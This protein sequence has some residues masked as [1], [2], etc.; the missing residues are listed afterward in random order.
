MDEVIIGRLSASV[1]RTVGEI[2]AQP[3]DEPHKNG[4][5]RS[6]ASTKAHQNKSPTHR[7][8]E[9]AIDAPTAIDDL[10]STLTND[11]VGYISY[12]LNQ[13][14]DEEPPR[15][16]DV[17]VI[18]KLTR[19]VI[20]RTGNDIAK[21]ERAFDFKEKCIEAYVFAGEIEAWLKKNAHTKNKEVLG[22]VANLKAI[23]QTG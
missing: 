20:A 21:A 18:Q 15:I 4:E 23:L 5:T 7:L 10:M 9:G 13:H 16:V 17:E 14:L 11:V 2:L 12:R 22:S 19:D 6:G 1:I 3:H 8:P